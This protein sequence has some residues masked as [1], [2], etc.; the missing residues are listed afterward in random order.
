MDSGMIRRG[1]DIPVVEQLPTEIQYPAAPARNYAPLPAEGFFLR[2]YGRI[3]KKRMWVIISTW[4]IIATLATVRTLR[5][6]PVYDATGRIAVNR[7]NSQNLGFKD[8]DQ[9]AGYDYDDY[10]IALETQVGILQSDAIAFQV[11]KNLKLNNNPA[12]AGVAAKP[13]TEPP[14]NSLQVDAPFESSLLDRFRSGLKLSV[15]PRTRIVEIHYSHPDPRLA[16]Q[17]VNMLINTYI[18][19]NFKTKF[20]STTQTSEWLSQQLADLALKVETSQ[21]KLVRY[22]KDHNI[23]GIDEKQNIVTSKLDELNKELTDALG[24]RIQKESAYK[25]ASAGNPEIF[26]KAESSTVLSQL[27]TQE[28]DLR[29]KYA[30]ATTQFGSSYPKV[31]QLGNQLKQVEESIQAEDKRIASRVQNEYLSALQREKLLTTALEVQKQEANQLNES[32]I[33]YNLLK[34]DAESNRQLYEGLLQK[35]KEAGVSAGL[36]SSNIRVVDLAR[37]PTSP[38]APNIPRN[39]VLGLALGLFGGVG[40]AL[41]LE[42][43]DNTV[44][45]PEEVQ[46]ISDLP[47]LGIIPLSKKLLAKNRKNGHARLSLSPRSSESDS[48][49]LIAFARPRS[50][51]AESYRALRTSILLSSLGS[52]PKVILVTSALPQEGKTTTS[53]NLAIVL[54]QRGGRVLLVDADLRRPGIHKALGLRNTSGLSTLMTGGNGSEDAIVSTEIPYLFVLTAGPPPPQPAELL[55]STL[56][57]D[58]LARWREE[59][60]HIVIDT[61][62]ALSVTDAVSLSVEADSVLVVVRSGQTT[63]AALRRVRDLLSHVNAR[64]TGVLVNAFDLHSGSSYYYQY[65]AKHYGRYYEEDD[66]PRNGTSAAGKGS[67][68]G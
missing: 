37:V 15:V 5:M 8:S 34:R 63:K 2:E 54:A 49:G 36:R 32:A 16:A 31:M 56:M 67:Q 57:K 39:I 17:I 21:E 59:F 68:H 47:S 51:L 64:I 58:Y 4:L 50:E 42:H 53:I 23:L 11:I 14:L 13:R 18:E 12:F 55:G 6:T 24:D 28:S 43:L 29:M 7:E 46:I 48:L 66:S 38:S 27:R 26:A 22:Q 65:D 60:A 33:E 20:E 61:P 40:L 9:G 10:F 30:E 35:L 1:R 45:T 19:Q 41:V 25:F 3:L 52:P 62:P 44:R